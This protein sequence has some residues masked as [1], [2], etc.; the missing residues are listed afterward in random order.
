MIDRILSTAYRVL[1][2]LRVVGRL[3]WNR[4][5]FAAA[6][7]RMF[8]MYFAVLYSLTFA[9]WV[10]PSDLLLEKLS[11]T[12]LWLEKLFNVDGTRLATIV[13]TRV[14][15]PGGTTMASLP[16]SEWVEL[17]DVQ[18]TS[19]ELR[20]FF[21]AKSKDDAGNGVRSLGRTVV[22]LQKLTA[23]VTPENGCDEQTILL[24]P[25]E[26]NLSA[27]EG[28]IDQMQI[29]STPDL[30]H[31]CFLIEKSASSGPALPATIKPPQIVFQEG[32]RNPVTPPAIVLKL[33]NVRLEPAEA[34]VIKLPSVVVQPPALEPA[35]DWSKPKS[36]PPIGMAPPALKPTDDWSRS[37]QAPSILL[38][39]PTMKPTDDWSKPVHTPSITLAPP[40]IE[41]TDD[42]SRPVQV[43]PITLAPPTIKTTE[44]T[45]MRLGAVYFSVA[46]PQ[47][48]NGPRCEARDGLGEVPPEDR[49]ELVDQDSLVRSSAQA[50][51]DPLTLVFVVGSADPIGESKYNDKL[52]EIRAETLRA[53]ILREACP[54]SG[55]CPSQISRHVIAT[56][57][58][59]MPFQE[60]LP[61]IQRSQRRAEV[62]VYK[63]HQWTAAGAQGA[64]R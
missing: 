4:V 61:S 59:A 49:S 43:P 21:A 54:R 42:W 35:D 55:S 8:F 56:R 26:V 3:V 17:V 10:M 32:W 7:L 38:A 53:T 47:L 30:A 28:S 24:S 57:A 27:Q 63:W 5:Y 6:Y 41:R 15:L 20:G 51:G 48:K 2:D 25:I 14:R 46:C 36:L 16:L 58:G 60:A 45:P 44:S 33:P 31:F 64:N 1:T 13:K 39:P 40:A 9:A 62:F 29:L 22:D 52:A 37:V 12:A 18:M 23:L 19:R 11:H 50:L 34:Q